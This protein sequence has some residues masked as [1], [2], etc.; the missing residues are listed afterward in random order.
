MGF[1]QDHSQ[2]AAPIADAAAQ[3]ALQSQFDKAF[4]AGIIPSQADPASA[5]VPP[6]TAAQPGQPI[7]VGSAGQAPLPQQ[8]PPITADNTHQNFLQRLGIDPNGPGPGTGAGG[9]RSVLDI[10]GRIADVGATI[11]GTPAL[12]QSNID[13]ATARAR[14]TQAN[15]WQQKFNVQKQT[16]GDQTIASGQHQLQGEVNTQTAQAVRGLSSVYDQAIAADPTGATAQAALAKAAPMVAQQLGIDQNSPQFQQLMQGL[17]TD[18][19]TTLKS[20]GEA[21]T[22]PTPS[23]PS[24]AVQLGDYIKANGSP[25]DY[26]AYVKAVSNPHALTDKD[27]ASLAIQMGNLKNNTAR[28]GAYVAATTP[29]TTPGGGTGGLTAEALDYAAKNYAA[30]GALPPLGQG[31][32]AAAT[33]TAI[34]NR[35]EAL[36]RGGGDVHDNPGAFHAGF[37]ANAAGLSQIQRTSNQILAAERT[38]NANADQVLATM[39][40]GAGT[41][42]IPVL[43]AWQN[44][45]RNG[46][47]GDP[48]VAKFNTAITTFA[49][50]Y[51]RVVSGATGGN[52]TS[53]SS[54]REAMHMINGAQTTPQLTA[55]INQMRVEMQNRRNG[56]AQ[57][58]GE[59]RN[60]M[61][62]PGAHHP[63]TPQGDVPVMTAD[64][65][66]S[67]P[68]GTRFRGVD[69][70]IYTRN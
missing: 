39:G 22:P 70:K 42:G 16:Q 21:L 33:R 59:L 2:V 27:R 14:A 52:V 66:R 29:V 38:A 55:V 12:Y 32:A 44:R 54:R 57:Q 35:A 41:T 36:T 26:Q 20:M 51:A 43:N 45:A 30:S 28:T 24:A 67:A 13:A 61:R 18:P 19:A 37:K 5:A 68:K 6:P 7:D 64:Q 58:V 47:Q 31:K 8:A 34:I 9:K 1:L 56:F 63:A 17:Q 11:G 69:G 10:L 62:L 4:G 49:T 25:E 60:N 23:S 15:D 48:N 65:A 3:Q 46:L 40:K 50:E 53:D